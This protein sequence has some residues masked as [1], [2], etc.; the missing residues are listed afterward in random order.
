M[1][2]KKILRKKKYY[3]KYNNDNDNDFTLIKNILKNKSRKSLKNNSRKSLKNNSKESLE[4]NSKESLENNSKKFLINKYKLSHNP[5]EQNMR[6]I[7]IRS[8]LDW[9]TQAF[10]NGN[11]YQLNIGNNTV[12][13]DLSAFHIYS[14]MLRKKL[15]EKKIESKI[16]CFNKNCYEK[17][18]G[19]SC[20]KCK[21]FNVLYSKKKK[22][23]KRKK[24]K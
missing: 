17:Y 8:D 16:I 4:N 23:K 1:Y 20:P 7:L 19:N 2:P 14:D 24:K 11:I 15:T 10:I 5:I 13:D 3:K 9:K 22:K 18:I 21:T 6:A 12:A